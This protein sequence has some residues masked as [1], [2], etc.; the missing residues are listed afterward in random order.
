M[1]IIWNDKLKEHLVKVDTV[2]ARLKNSDFQIVR[3]N[4][5]IESIIK[6]N[7]DKLL[8]NEKYHAYIHL[9]AKSPLLYYIWLGPKNMEPRS[10]WWQDSE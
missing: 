6:I 1:A 4:E 5:Q 10:D 8:E 3:T 7:L 2:E 9:D